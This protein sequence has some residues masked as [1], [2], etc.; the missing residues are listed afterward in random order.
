METEVNHD[1]D[2]E[3]DVVSHREVYEHRQVPSATSTPVKERNGRTSYQLPNTPPNSSPGR[4]GDDVAISPL[5]SFQ[6]ASP[7]HSAV[8][9]SKLSFISSPSSTD[10]SREVTPDRPILRPAV[11]PP[12]PRAAAASRPRRPQDPERN[13]DCNAKSSKRAR[14]RLDFNQPTS[15]SLP[16]L[17]EHIFGHPPATSHG[18]EEDCLALMRV[19]A[20]KKLRAGKNA[21]PF[22]TVKAMW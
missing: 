18:A 11:P 8:L 21:V 15:F 9:M 12:V 19:C 5:T 2:D 6:I 16:R 20:A 14:K 4:N 7:P 17:H 3:L 13:G 1:T 22:N 10:E